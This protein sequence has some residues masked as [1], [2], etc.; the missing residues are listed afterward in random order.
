MSTILVTIVHLH[1]LPN[2]Y[3]TSYQGCGNCESTAGHFG[4]FLPLLSCSPYTLYTA[5]F[6]FIGHSLELSDMTGYFHTPAS[7]YSILTYTAS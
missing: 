3:I 6:Q 7:Y 1:T 2:Q 5:Q 4:L